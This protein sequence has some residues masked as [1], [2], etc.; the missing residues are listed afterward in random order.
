MSDWLLVVIPPSLS[1]QGG[2]RSVLL[3]WLL[4]FA[5]PAGAAWIPNGVPICVNPECGARL[6]VAC[7]DGAGG[8]FIAWQG[9]TLSNLD[10]NVYVHHI[11]ATGDLDPLWPPLGVLVCGAPDE[12][13]PRSIV[14]DGSG[15]VF[16]AW[17]DRRDASTPPNHTDLY[18]S[19]VTGDGAVAPR[20]PADGAPACTTRGNQVSPRLTT[21]GAGGA[22][23]AWN[24]G[25]DGTSHGS[26]IYA[27]HFTVDGE[28]AAGWPVNGRPIVAIGGN[29]FIA[30]AFL[31]TEAGGAWFIWADGRGGMGELYGLK[32]LGDGTL[33]PGWNENG[34]LLVGGPTF[35]GAPSVVSDG[36]GGA[37]LGWI[38]SIGDI[39]TFD[40]YAIR[41]LA[42][43]SPHPSWPV[44]GLPVCTA[45]YVQQG[46]H[47]DADASGLALGW[48][49]YR[50]INGD[51][52]GQ[53]LTPDG[54]IA[55]GW[56]MDGVLVADRYQF[57]QTEA[58]IA[59]GSGG[60][61]VAFEHD[62]VP[63][64]VYVQHMGVNAAPA[65]GWPMHGI[66]VADAPG[67]RRQ[68]DACL[69]SDGA[70]GAIVVWW[71]QRDGATG[72]YAQK[73]VPDGPVAVALSLLSVEA[74]PDRVRLV[75]QGTGAGVLDAQVERRDENDPWQTLGAASVEGADRLTYDDPSVTAGTRY[76]YR[77]RYR[78][79]GVERVTAA[80]WVE[81]PGRLEVALAGLRPN[82]A[83][84][85]AA[86]AFTL[87]EQAPA[88]L[89]V[90][91][92][93]GRRVFVRDVGVLGPGRHTVRLDAGTRLAPGVYLIRLTQGGRSLLSRGV[94]IR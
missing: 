68:D 32:V 54:S 19:R 78:D 8:A 79:E 77:L 25:R 16:V 5:H 93:A 59:D 33:E 39:E 90:L 20:W 34:N 29:Q 10:I 38:D 61:F 37:Y 75:W 9:A 85:S 53:R 56:V 4:L 89:E 36:A 49:D 67:L 94:M 30:S 48:D 35:K 23:L 24:D 42:D 88:M 22:F 71:E 87:S 31:P 76:A 65:P 82:P 80:S 13:T 40:V 63:Q 11:L 6:P 51:I 72:I 12:Q 84:G 47:A 81:V 60:L 58:L 2:L 55:T 66:P 3:A 27:Q 7:S 74:A 91:D 14:A 92:I 44:T 21:S 86:V 46:L 64:K 1:R 18:V 69:V 41:L 73:L 28:V 26:D 43:G 62:E 50:G 70:G 17:E 45:Y 15:G 57:E 83:S 52:Y